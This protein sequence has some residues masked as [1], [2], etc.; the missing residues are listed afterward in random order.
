MIFI[1]NIFTGLCGIAGP[2]VVGIVAPNQTLTEW[3]LVFWIMLGVAIVTNIV[4]VIFAS[5]EVQ[6]WNDPNFE[7]KK[8]REI[9][10]Q[11]IEA[12]ELLMRE[13]IRIVATEGMHRC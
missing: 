9:F 7:R 10:E 13:T 1:I 8:R 2:Y 6:D 3:T 12:E 5:G 4:F 11:P